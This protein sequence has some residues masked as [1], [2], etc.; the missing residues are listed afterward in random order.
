M[1]RNLN[2]NRTTP[3]IEHIRSRLDD[4][5]IGINLY[6]I[7]CYCDNIIVYLMSKLTDEELRYVVSHLSIGYTPK[8]PVSFRENVEEMVISYNLR[9]K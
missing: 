2:L 4:Q 3:C 9:R 5:K 7:A 6:R 1:T 8:Y